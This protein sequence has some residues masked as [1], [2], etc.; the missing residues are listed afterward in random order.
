MRLLLGTVSLL[1]LA[2]CGTQGRLPDLPQLNMTEFQGATGKAIERA[3]SEAR[4]HPKDAERVLQLAKVLHAH[5]QYRTASQCYARAYGLDPRRFDTLYCWGQAL[6]ADGSYG[7]AADRL[8]QALALRSDSIPAQLKL[9]E[10]FRQSGD[11]TRSAAIT[12]QILARDPGN[13]AAHYEY[14]RTLTGNAAME[15]FRKA[16]AIFPRYGAA[17]FAL[18]GSYRRIG[19][20]TQAQETLRNYERDKTLVPP[21]NDPDMGSVQALDASAAGMLR[22]AIEQEAEGRLDEALALHE[23][24]IELDPKLVE[25]YVNLISLY[26]RL[27]RDSEAVEAYHKAIA[28]VPNRADAYYNFGVFCL[29]RGRSNEAKTALEHAIR[30]EPR[31]AEALH[32]LAVILER[33]GKWDQAAALYRQALEARPSYQLAHFHLGRIYANQ[34]KYELAIAEFQSSIQPPE[35]RNPT[36]LYALAATH[37]RAGHRDIAAGMMR[38][39]RDLAASQGQSSLVANIDRDL[40]TLG[41]SR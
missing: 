9:A 1:V 11:L 33:E 41:V 26:G 16:L 12:Q 21:I 6:A 14:G 38:K 7:P 37:A 5:E 31:H 18:A 4:A 24:A 13:A 15:E 2:G 39:A 30:I 3:V 20:N 36:Y 8:R 23:R 10:V 32:N 35:D 29:E 22:R 40:A 19:D 17:Q 34:K 27:A 28:L 25:A